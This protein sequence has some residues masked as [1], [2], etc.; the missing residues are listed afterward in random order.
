[1]DYMLSIFKILNKL[2]FSN[3]WS[4]TSSLYADDVWCEVIDLD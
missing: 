1:M 2:P 3:I 4:N